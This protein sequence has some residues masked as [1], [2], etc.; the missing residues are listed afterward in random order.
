MKNNLPVFVA[1]LLL[2]C[3]CNKPDVVPDKND[4]DPGV[5][6]QDTKTAYFYYYKNS[7]QYLQLNPEY[8]FVSAKTNDDISLSL[9]VAATKTVQMK[10]DLSVKLEKK[11]NT[12]KD[13]S[14][15]EFKLSQAK[16]ESE[17]LALLEKVKQDE[18]IETV[19]PCFKNGQ[20]EKIGLSNFFYVK[21][22]SVDDYAL[23]E[24]FSVAQKAVIVEQNK[25]MPLCYTLSCTKDAGLN[26]MQLAN[27]YY[28][29][30]QFEFA[31]PDLMGDNLENCATDPLFPDQWSLRN[32]G[33][34]GGTIGLDIKACDAWGISKGNGINVA[35]IDQGIQLN[36]E[37][38]AANMHP[39]S[40]DAQTGRSPSVVRG[41]HGTACAGIIG[42]NDN[43][44]G[45]TGVAPDCR[46]MSVSQGLANNPTMLAELANAFNWSW[47]NGAD[48]ISNSWRMFS[49]SAMLDNAISNAI[50]NGR[51][52][53]GCVVVFSSGNDNSAVNYP[54]SS[55]PNILVVGA[56][57]P[58]GQRKN[59]GSCDTEARWGSSFGS[60]LDVIAPGTLIATTDRSNN[61][62][63]N[64]NAP[65]HIV[66]GGGNKR[67]TDVANRNYTALFTGTSSACPHAAGVAALVLAA[68]PALTAQQVRD[69]I[70]RSATKAGTYSYTT[71]ADRPNGTWNQEMGYGLVNAHGAVLLARQ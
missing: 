10:E 51:G 62:G 39:L 38:L 25:F 2:L 15:A 40:F 20:G 68:N 4:G 50:N 22:R 9:D 52:G 69:I 33:Q 48:V 3:A 24:K 1:L 42:A 64:P 57:S 60:Q 54:A 11:L 59:P 61:S 37:D 21:L 35:V 47:Q 30:G 49:R 6:K 63:Y 7:K 70:E 66:Y 13:H 65:Q 17:Y 58:C 32:T 8:F 18:T 43:L 53:K 41:D 5:S 19:A 46:L 14:W 31:E 23:L 71:S 26:A 27:R 44:I 28:E 36:H 45:V 12:G 67:T 55:N 56:M 16:T 34:Y 29:S